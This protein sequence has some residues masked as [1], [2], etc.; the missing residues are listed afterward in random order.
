[1]LVLTRKPG[2]QIIINGNIIVNVIKTHDN[3][4]RLGISAPI[5]TPIIRAELLRA[6]AEAG[7]TSDYHAE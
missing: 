3:K 5:E 1:M 4:V 2:E 7:A 6:L